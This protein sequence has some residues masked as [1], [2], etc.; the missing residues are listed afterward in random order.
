MCGLTRTGSL[1]GKEREV[2]SSSEA[3]FDVGDSDEEDEHHG[4]DVG[5]AGGARRV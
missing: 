5:R 4:A 1:K 3:I 2:V